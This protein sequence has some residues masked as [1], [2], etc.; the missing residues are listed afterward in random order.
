MDLPQAYRITTLVKILNS[1]PNLAAYYAIANQVMSRTQSQFAI[2][3]YVDQNLRQH[4]LG[5]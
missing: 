5:I 4:N 3:W 1:L 2:H